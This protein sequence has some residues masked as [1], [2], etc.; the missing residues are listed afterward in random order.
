MLTDQII[1]YF[2]V[3]AFVALSLGLSMS[4]VRLPVFTGYILAGALLGPHGIGFIADLDLMN[5]LGSVGVVLLLFFIGVEI[6]PKE[7]IEKWRI[8]LLGT[9][10]QVMLSVGVVSL[11]GLFFNWPLARI[12][13]IGFV[14]S[15]S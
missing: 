13:L 12:V 7:I 4:L 6:S 3:C 10:L 14:I 2:V 1:I 9:L 15:L 11:L 8:A 5:Q